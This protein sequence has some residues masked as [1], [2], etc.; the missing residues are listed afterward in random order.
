MAAAPI[1]SLVTPRKLNINT[2]N[3]ITE[4]KTVERTSNCLTKDTSGVIEI[5]VTEMDN[6][7]S[8]FIVLLSP[9]TFIVDKTP[10]VPANNNMNG[11]TT[12]KKPRSLMTSIPEFSVTAM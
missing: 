4:K 10:N 1:S 11:N 5:N 6:A 8:K 7:I 9:N 12:S 2:I 3:I